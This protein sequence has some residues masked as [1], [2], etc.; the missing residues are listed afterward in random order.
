MLIKHADRHLVVGLIKQCSI[1][2]DVHAKSYL[3]MLIMNLNLVVI[4]LKHFCTII[5]FKN[6]RGICLEDYKQRIKNK[7]NVVPMEPGCYLMKDRNDQVI[8]VGKAKN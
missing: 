2:H 6:R 8:Y 3:K 5:H 7:L 4:S 1:L